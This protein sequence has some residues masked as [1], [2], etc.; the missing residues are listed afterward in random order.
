MVWIYSQGQAFYGGGPF[1]KEEAWGCFVHTHVGTPFS[2]AIII[3]CVVDSLINKVL[4]AVIGAL[5]KIQSTLTRSKA[6]WRQMKFFCVNLKNIL[7]PPLKVE[8]YCIPIDFKTEL[9]RPRN[10]L[11]FIVSISWHIQL[12]VV[13]EKQL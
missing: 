6:F 11:E 1:P 10:V 8:H 13:W 7:F 5:C 9:E 4:S 12:M 2:S 3:V